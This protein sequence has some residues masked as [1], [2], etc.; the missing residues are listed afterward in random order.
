M[1]LECLFCR[2][3]VAADIFFP[4]CSLCGEPLLVSS[5]S[6]K[7][8]FKKK[9]VLSLEKFI[10]FLPLPSIN[11]SLSLGEGNTSL[12]RLSTIEEKCNLPLLYAKNETSNPSHSFKDRGTV[13]SILVA[14][15]LGVKRIGTVS[16]G[17]MAASTAAYGAR[18]GIE[19]FI[20]L[21]EGTSD[22]KVKSVAVYGPRLF[23]V[24]GDYGLL[25]NKSFS[26][27][28]KFRIYFINSVD[29]FRIEGYKL[30]GFEI[31]LQLEEAPRFI[32]VPLSSGG[33]LI[34]LMRAFL[35]L[36]DQGLI[37]DIPTFVGVQAAGCAPLANAF[38]GHKLKFTRISKAD[39]VAHAISNPDPPAG[40]LV[41]KLIKEYRGIIVSVSDDEILS[42]QQILAEEAGIFCQPASATTL[43]AVFKLKRENKLNR[44]EKKVLI[45][46]GSG[47]KAPESAKIPAEAIPTVSLDNLEN[48]FQN[49]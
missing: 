31:Y 13:V 12:I 1:E 33:H 21:K 5:P 41:L 47:L 22:H 24:S 48:A 46:T 38:S 35:D 8:R 39:T 34:G 19:T 23:R 26:L 28:R 2:E 20:L 36:K 45:I 49:L 27:G 9:A 29:P 10:D 44:N 11:R 42:A 30:T 17:N 32:F 4:F 25:F 37:P 18:A 15:D 3:K 6:R 16:T 7:K 43:A 14:V 40:N